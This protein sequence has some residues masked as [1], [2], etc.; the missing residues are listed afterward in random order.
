MHLRKT[1]FQLIMKELCVPE[2]TVNVALYAGNT[3]LVRSSDL[4]YHF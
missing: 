1:L 2:E 4:W 3:R